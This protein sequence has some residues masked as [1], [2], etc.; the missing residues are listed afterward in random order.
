ML[1]EKEKC[2]D[3]KKKLKVKYRYTCHTTQPYKFE[4]FV[5]NLQYKYGR[6]PKPITTQKQMDLN[7]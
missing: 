3:L 5:L 7:A 4:L 6:K 2:K 1:R